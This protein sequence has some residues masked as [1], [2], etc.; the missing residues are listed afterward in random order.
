MEWAQDGRGYS[1]SKKVIV[2]KRRGAE[3]RLVLLGPT[4][5]QSQA[6]IYNLAP[7]KIQ[8]GTFLDS[9]ETSS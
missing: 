4:S 6:P 2:L 8:G 5:N 7:G 3:Q 9:T 1:L